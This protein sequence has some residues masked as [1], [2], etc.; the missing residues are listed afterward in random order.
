MGEQASLTLRISRLPGAR[1]TP[2]PS[3]SPTPEPFGRVASQFENADLMNPDK[4]ERMIR[5]A[6]D[7]LLA[8]EFKQLS[9]IQ[10]RRLAAWMRNDP[11][12]RERLVRAFEK[13]L[14]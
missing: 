4:R 7:G 8:Q 12:V 10:R 9:L 1:G 2:N 6:V 13:I 14:S 5:I 3:Q 11:L